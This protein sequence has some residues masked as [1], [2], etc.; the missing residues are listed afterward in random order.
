MHWGITVSMLELLTSTNLKSIIAS[1]VYHVLKH[2]ERNVICGQSGLTYVVY[3][4]KYFLTVFNK[5]LFDCYTN[6]NL[7]MFL[8]TILN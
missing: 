1:Q 3:G 7:Y 2:N 6:I 4:K 8:I 5:T